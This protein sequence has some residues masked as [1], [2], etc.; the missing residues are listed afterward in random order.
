MRRTLVS[1]QVLTTKYLQLFRMGTFRRHQRNHDRMCE[2]LPPALNTRATSAP[3][4]L[5]VCSMRSGIDLK[6]PA[7]DPVV[8]AT[9]TRRRSRLWIKAARGRP[10]HLEP[11]RGFSDRSSMLVESGRYD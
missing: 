4:L 2:L 5:Y 10:K 9:L 6:Q 11:I 8:A 3:R 7:N 1:K